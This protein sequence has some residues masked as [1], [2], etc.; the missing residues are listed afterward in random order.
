MAGRPVAELESVLAEIWQRGRTRTRHNAHAIDPHLDPSCYPLLVAL[1]RHESLPMSQLVATLE[2]GKSTVTRQIDAA[3]RLGLVRRSP[4][5]DDARA[6]V[7]ALTELGRE[8]YTEVTD[9]QIADW[10]EHLSRWDPDDIRTLTALLRKFLASTGGK[11][12]LE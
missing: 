3:A 4:D 6:R 7:V 10:R 12:E 8:R 2:V 11:D 1:S 9:S 5:P